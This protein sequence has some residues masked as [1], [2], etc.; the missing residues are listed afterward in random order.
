MSTEELEKRKKAQLIKSAALEFTPQP[1]WLHTIDPDVLKIIGSEKLTNL[2]KSLPFSNTQNDFAITLLCEKIEWDEESIKALREF[3]AEFNDALSK[4]PFAGIGRDEKSELVRVHEMKASIL[5]WQNTFIVKFYEL[6]LTADIPLDHKIT[7]QMNDYENYCTKN[8]ITDPEFVINPTIPTGFDTICPDHVAFIPS[9]VKRASV[10]NTI[11]TYRLLYRTCW[12][13][14]NL[15][16]KEYLEQT[17]DVS[18]GELV[19]SNV[20]SR[21]ITFYDNLLVYIDCQRNI[22]ELFIPKHKVKSTDLFDEMYLHQQ[23]G[24]TYFSELK[25]EPGLFANTDFI[26]GHDKDEKDQIYNVVKFQGFDAGA[27]LTRM[28]AC[29]MNYTN[30]ESIETVTFCLKYKDSSNQ[31]LEYSNKEP[32][33]RDLNYLVALTC[34]RGTNITKIK[35]AFPEE[36]GKL[37]DI[38]IAK[39][40]IKHR[41]NMTGAIPMSETTLGRICAALPSVMAVLHFDNQTSPI[42]SDMDLDFK[43][44]IDHMLLM[45][46]IVSIVPTGFKRHLPLKEDTQCYAFL[47]FYLQC[48]ISEQLA[49]GGIDLVEQLNIFKTIAKTSSMGASTRTLVQKRCNLSEGVIKLWN[50]LDAE[51]ATNYKKWIVGK[52]SSKV[53]KVLERWIIREAEATE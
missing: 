50:G 34:N 16:R 3:C 38:L 42:I 13:V 31:V 8:K 41:G 6:V 49:P 30:D 46:N 7:N 23:E 47:Y 15:K 10:I 18:P 12:K 2:A 44:D 32:L 53:H 37:I 22:G 21:G 33:N 14:N 5:N 25:V 1:I 4:H 9:V 29:H 39:Y 26:F 11:E 51:V 24:F 19:K 17:K 36:D 27:L 20:R 28:M 40:E 52:N 45:Q 35:K 48:K 43:N